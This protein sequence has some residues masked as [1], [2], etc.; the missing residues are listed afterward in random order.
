MTKSWSVLKL[1]KERRVVYDS[2]KHNYN[3]NKWLDWLDKSLDPETTKC[4]LGKS[5]AACVSLSLKSWHVW[6]PSTLL[7]YKKPHCRA[8]WC[9]S[10][11][12]QTSSSL[13]YWCSDVFIV[14]CVLLWEKATLEI[15]NSIQIWVSVSAQLLWS[16]RIHTGV[17]LLTHTP[18]FH[19]DETQTGGKKT[20]V[21]RD[22][23]DAVLNVK[24]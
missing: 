7:G 17:K 15:C 4:Y 23:C 3:K 20:L 18:P 22:P 11:Q 19:V 10:L 1:S 5:H 13:K 8:C 12:I 24:P 2:S 14:T 9:H 6:F 21:E 16:V